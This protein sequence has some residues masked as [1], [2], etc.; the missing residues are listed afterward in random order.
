MHEKYLIHIFVK[1]IDQFY[2]YEEKNKIIKNHKKKKSRCII[3]WDC[4]TI[5]KLNELCNKKNMGRNVSPNHNM[6]GIIR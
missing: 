6:H 4:F 2:M 1:Y 3:L 5:Q